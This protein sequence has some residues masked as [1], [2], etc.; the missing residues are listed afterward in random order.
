MLVSIIKNSCI[1]L[2]LMSETEAFETEMVGV[3][4]IVQIFTIGGRDI[5]MTNMDGKDEMGVK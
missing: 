5:T 2:L 1:W 3:G 4:G